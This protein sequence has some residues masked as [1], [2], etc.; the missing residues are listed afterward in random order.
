MKNKQPYRA[1]FINTVN[2]TVE[3]VVITGGLH[4]MYKLIGCDLVDIRP[5]DKENSIVVDDEGLLT[6]DDV[7]LEGK[8]QCDGFFFLM[9]PVELHTPINI[10][11]GRA[12]IVGSTDKSPGA[13]I[14]ADE[15]RGYIRFVPDDKLEVAVQAAKD[16]CNC[17]AV[18]ASLEEYNAV[19]KGV[20]G[21]IEATYEEIFSPS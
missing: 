15:I 1:V 2:K 12:L 11:A 19:L 9:H 21:I 17:T 8:P 13:T 7:D 3:D 18:C 16:L 5:I 10:Y 4:E 6:V 20:K 14:T